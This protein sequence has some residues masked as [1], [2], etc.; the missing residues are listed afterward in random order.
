[1]SVLW[2]YFIKPLWLYK[3]SKGNKSQA[4]DFKNRVKHYIKYKMNKVEYPISFF[5]FYYI[6]KMVIGTGWRILH[7]GREGDIDNKPMFRKRIN[8]MPLMKE[9]ILEA[10]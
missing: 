6:D 8:G 1:M 3:N 2:K 4:K 10:V 5:P 9:Y 7:S